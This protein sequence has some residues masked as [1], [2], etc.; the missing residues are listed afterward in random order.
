[1]L[2]F[3]QVIISNSKVE[4]IELKTINKISRYNDLLNLI[5]DNETGKIEKKILLNNSYDNNSL[6]RVFLDSSTIIQ[7]NLFAVS[8]YERTIHDFLNDLS[9]FTKRS[10]TIY[11][12]E[13]LIDSL[14]FSNIDKDIEGEYFLEVYFKT[15]F[16]GFLRDSIRKVSA[17]NKGIIRIVNNRNGYN[18]YISSITIIEKL[19]DKQVRDLNTSVNIRKGNISI[20]QEPTLKFLDIKNVVIRGK[21]LDLQWQVN[22]VNGEVKIELP[23]SVESFPSEISRFIWDVPEN[24]KPGKYKI[25]IYTGNNRELKDIV[26]IRIKR[27]IPLGVKLGIIPILTI[28]FLIPPPPPSEELPLPPSLSE[29]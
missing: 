29:L 10:D 28:P 27:K 13:F 5:I 18:P 1:M 21:E 23:G 8:K 20:I 16:N 26:D 24:L 17:Y 3:G 12:N 4:E 9:L 6:D 22:N 25:L 11:N 7:D 19:P 15:I 2:A 14:S